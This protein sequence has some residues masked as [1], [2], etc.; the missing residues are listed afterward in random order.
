MVA[1]AA[2]AANIRA[3]TSLAVRSTVVLRGL[4][5]VGS[6]D[7]DGAGGASGVAFFGVAVVFG[8]GAFFAVFFAGFVAVVFFAADA[9][10]VVFAAAFFDTFFDA[11]LVG[12]FFVVDDDDAFFLVGVDA[13]LEARVRGRA[14]APPRTTDH[15]A[16]SAGGGRVFFD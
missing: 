10:D 6:S 9:F 11:F 16:G 1:P 5:T 14:G 7:S 15:D 2:R 8:V 13:F 4:T 3:W 12:A